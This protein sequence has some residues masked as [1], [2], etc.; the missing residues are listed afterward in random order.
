M[1]FYDI[2]WCFYILV[3]NF[4]YSFIILFQERDKL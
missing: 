3:D 1:D 4:D 2:L